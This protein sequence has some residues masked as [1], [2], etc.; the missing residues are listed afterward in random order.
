MAEPRETPLLDSRYED[1]LLANL[2][3]LNDRIDAIAEADMS[4]RRALHNDIG[5]LRREVG[6]VREELATLRVRLSVVW[7]IASG[8]GGALAI[9]AAKLVGALRG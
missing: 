5:A 3:Q 9:G 6:A 2:Q 7:G 4:G 1:L 8:L